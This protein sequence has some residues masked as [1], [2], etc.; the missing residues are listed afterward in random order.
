VSTVYNLGDNI[1]TD[2]VRFEMVIDRMMYRYKSQ[3]PSPE[4]WHRDVIPSDRIN[5]DN[6][7]YGGWLNLDSTDQYFSCIPGSHLGVKLSE[8]M[9]GFA[10]VPKDR[11]ESVSKYRQKFTIPPGHMIV[12][13]Q[14][15]LHEVVA[16][17]AKTNM[18]R[19]FTAWSTT[20]RQ[21]FIHPDM[22]ERL[23]SQN[24]VP[25]PS[26]Q[27]PP[28]YAANHGSFYLHKPFKPIPNRDHSVSL[29][30]W[31]R[32]TMQPR[33][34]AQKDGAKGKYTIVSRYLKSLKDYDFR[35]YPAYTQEEISLV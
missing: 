23:L 15:I 4:S 12:F 11:I 10:A 32:D 27:R 25:L 28:I 17:K 21:N 31:S 6:E 24:I 3:Q 18:M 7:I 26:G 9:E 16:N 5:T 13:P 29:I 19:L 14:Y 35:M 22:I 8:L 34:L 2:P 33:T 30:E 1:R 20:T